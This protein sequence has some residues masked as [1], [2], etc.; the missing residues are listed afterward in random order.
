M[1]SLLCQKIGGSPTEKFDFILSIVILVVGCVM[2]SVLILL[3]FFKPPKYFQNA[4]FQARYGSLFEGLKM[5]QT[6]NS[7][8][9]YNVILLA[10]RIIYSFICVYLAD[11]QMQQ[12]QCYTLISLLSLMYIMYYKPFI[13]REQNMLEIFNELAVLISSYHLLMFTNIDQI[14]P[15]THYLED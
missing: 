3:I 12:I 13:K 9:W 15:L 2:I 1:Y 4:N 5:S 6:G 14:N 8:L 7:R 11:Y 10:R